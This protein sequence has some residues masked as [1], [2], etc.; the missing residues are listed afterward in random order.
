MG[1]AAGV[2]AQK[3]PQRTV[4]KLA[5]RQVIVGPDRDDV[6]MAS[7][8]V[9][10]KGDT[11]VMYDYGDTSMKAFSL[12]SGARLWKTG[13]AGGGPGEFANPTSLS[14][15]PNGKLWIYDPEQDRMSIFTGSGKLEREFRP[16]FQPGRLVRSGNRSIALHIR[17]SKQFAAV[18]DDA[19][20]RVRDM[21]V[22]TWVSGLDELGRDL[23]AG[24]S[25]EFWVGGFIYTGRLIAG[26]STNDVVFELPAIQTQAAMRDT[27]FSPRPGMIVRKPNPK[28]K[29]VVRSISV[30]DGTVFVYGWSLSKTERYLDVY[31]LR[32]RKY[33]KSYVLPSTVAKIAVTRAGVAALEEIDDVPALTFYAFK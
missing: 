4:A 16:S 29:S 33:V 13:R 14:V 10:A 22:P 5:A 6:L 31:D 30:L 8:L 7:S 24:T 3:A 20:K 28:A 17:E 27:V 32:T 23:F 25:N 9:V 21:A 12:A 19:G 1:A 2:S 11:I 18:V 15:G 26:S